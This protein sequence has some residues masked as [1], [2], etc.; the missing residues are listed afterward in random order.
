[1][2]HQPPNPRRDREAAVCCVLGTH[3]KTRN[4]FH[5][6]LIQ[7][8][9]APSGSQLIQSRE[10]GLWKRHCLALRT[11]SLS[12]L[13]KCHNLAMCPR[14]TL[15]VTDLPLTSKQEAGFTV[16]TSGLLHPTP[17]VW[18]SVPEGLRHTW[19]PKAAWGWILLA[20]PVKIPK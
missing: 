4:S 1:M 9:P 19:G 2:L 3:G 7:A 13:E 10:P 8:L 6:S 11:F 5:G 16:K 17:A 12:V 15:E 14:C 18:A 20:P